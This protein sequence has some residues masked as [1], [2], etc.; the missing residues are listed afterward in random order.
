MTFFLVGVAMC[1]AATSM[2]ML[3]IGRVISGIGGAGLF[4][5]VHICISDI[6]TLRKRGTYHGILSAVNG[7]GAA[8]G[9]TIG[10]L[11]ASQGANGWRCAFYFQ[12]PI[13]F[14][15]GLA[16]FFF[17]PRIGT[18]DIRLFKTKVKTVDYMG[19]LLF[20]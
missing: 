11:F 15:A 20:V 12:L 14:V 17:L 18:T 4:S 10:G 9:P 7:A 3:I 8:L 13:G 6:V 5:M 19:M 1:G 2:I 16:T